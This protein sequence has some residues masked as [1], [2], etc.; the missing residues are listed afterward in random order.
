[1]TEATAPAL[2]VENTSRQTIVIAAKPTSATA[3]GKRPRD[4]IKPGAVF[5]LA[6]GERAAPPDW[7]LK[8]PVY[9]AERKAM[10]RDFDRDGREFTVPRISLV[11]GDDGLGAAQKVA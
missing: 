8:L 7:V 11:H 5:K 1:M 3:A 10:V 4:D 2:I 6:P 9:A